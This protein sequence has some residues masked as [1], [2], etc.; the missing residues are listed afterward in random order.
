GRSARPGRRIDS[1]ARRRSF[2]PGPGHR[3]AAPRGARTDVGADPCGG[4]R[5][6]GRSR[7]CRQ[8]DR[9]GGRARCPRLSARRSRG[10]RRRRARGRTFGFEAYDFA[11]RDP[12]E[13]VA[14]VTRGLLADTVLVCAQS[15]APEVAN[16][17]MRLCR[18]KGRVVIVGDVR[19]DLDR[20]LMYEKELDLLISTSYGPGRYDPSYEERG[21]D[22]PA[23][24]VRFTL[25]RNMAA[26]L[27]LV[28]D[29]RVALR[30]L[31]DRVFPLAEA[32][33]AYAT[34][35]DEST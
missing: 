1:G 23:P 19:L 21:I 20:S 17:A 18:R 35:D 32:A 9:R 33:S 16:L 10:M 28:R 6:R 29:G 12:R 14:R 15:N 3:S 7:V 25:N 24:Y 5:T 4:R 8:R 22:Y 26:F 34:I 13:E 27:D 11:A 30:P 2:D 31:I